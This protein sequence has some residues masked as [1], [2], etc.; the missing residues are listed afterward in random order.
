[1]FLNKIIKVM[2]LSEHQQRLWCNMVSA[3]EDFRKGK[4]QYTTLVYELESSLDTGEF[5]CESIIGE[6]YD[7]WT[8]LETL[9]ATIGDIATIEDA[10]Q[11]LLAMNTF[12]KSKL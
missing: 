12:L 10:D 4:I 9:A 6:W 2:Q 8:P 1:M 7:H 11:Y 3:I 5:N